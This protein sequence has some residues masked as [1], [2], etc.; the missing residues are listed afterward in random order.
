[1]RDIQNM[2]AGQLYMPAVACK[3]WENSTAI[4]ADMLRTSTGRS[5][6]VFHK[7][8]VLCSKLL[9]QCKNKILDKNAHHAFCTSS[10]NTCHIFSQSWCSPIALKCGRIEFVICMS[11]VQT[12]STHVA[13]IHSHLATSPSGPNRD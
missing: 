8:S 4:L 5:T 3:A 12:L 7:L 13:R 11:D 1:M 10:F 9:D 6:D 2:L